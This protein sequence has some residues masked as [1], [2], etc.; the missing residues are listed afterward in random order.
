MRFPVSTNMDSILACTMKYL[1]VYFASANNC[2][3]SPLDIWF[4]EV[5]RGSE[6]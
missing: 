4:G 2:K 5:R 6:M 1:F 3:R